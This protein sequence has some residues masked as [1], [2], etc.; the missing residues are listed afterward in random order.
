[1]PSELKPTQ[2]RMIEILAVRV[3]RWKKALLADWWITG[4]G[5]GEGPATISCADWN[6]FTDRNT[7]AEVEKQLTPEQRRQYMYILKYKP[8]LAMTIVQEWWFIRHAD[9]AVCA[10][11]I[12]GIVAPEE[13][14]DE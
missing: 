6:P 8:G 10:E 3:M 14:Q 9:P 4:Y 7:L 13:F 2:E 5:Q 12:A 1:M 11:A